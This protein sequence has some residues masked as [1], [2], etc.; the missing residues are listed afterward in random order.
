MK[1]AEHL[2]DAPR[3]RGFPPGTTID[4]WD[5][6]GSLETL[7]EG[8]HE[9]GDVVDEDAEKDRDFVVWP[10]VLELKLGITV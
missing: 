3:S 7:S 10:M 4:E 2:D 9:Q 1:Q 5:P 8:D 6:P